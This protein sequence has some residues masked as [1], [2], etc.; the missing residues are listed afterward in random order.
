MS[1]NAM[2]R[3]IRNNGVYIISYWVGRRGKSMVHTVAFKYRNGVYTVYNDNDQDTRALPFPSFS[4]IYGS[5]SF[6][7]G[8][9]LY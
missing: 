7:T 8:Y 4:S 9:Y 5:G 1:A 6:I 2:K 3:L